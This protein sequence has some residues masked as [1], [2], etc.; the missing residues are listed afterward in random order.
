[1]DTYGRFLFEFLDQFFSG[2]KDMFMGIITGIQKIFNIPAYMELIKHY[3][4]DFSISEWLLTGFAIIVLAIII[5]VIV[6][7][8][9]FFLKKHM[10]LRKKILNQE[11]LLAEIDNLNREVETLVDEK[12]KILSMEQPDLGIDS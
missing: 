3:K 12:M 9:V 8:I 1:M 7:L 2:F 10:R 6:G 4:E 11:E 5:A